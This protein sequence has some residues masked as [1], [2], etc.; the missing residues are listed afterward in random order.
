MTDIVSTADLSVP[1]TAPAGFAH[2]E[3]RKDAATA[4]LFVLN[5][6]MLLVVLAAFW[7]PVVLFWAAWALAPL[8]LLLIVAI[9]RGWLL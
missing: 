4:S 5:V 6:L 9:T 3:R 1:D 8:T 2:N 7:T